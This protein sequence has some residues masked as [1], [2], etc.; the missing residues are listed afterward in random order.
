MMAAAMQQ[1]QQ[2]QQH[3]PGGSILGVAREKDDGALRALCQVCSTSGEVGEARKACVLVT[4][5]RRESDLF[6][7]LL[8]ERRDPP[9]SSSTA[10]VAAGRGG[11]KAASAGLTVLC[12]MSLDDG[13]HLEMQSAPLVVKVVNTCGQRIAYLLEFGRAMDLVTFQRAFTSARGYFRQMLTLRTL[14]ADSFW[15]GFASGAGG[16][17]GVFIL[18]CTCWIV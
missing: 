10:D 11:G 3:P 9:S 5:Y 16:P 2:Q 1:Q 15:Q 18:M 8:R 12:D 13:V 4:I 17:A 6:A 14:V 7:L